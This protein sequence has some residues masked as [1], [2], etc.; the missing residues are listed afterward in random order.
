MAKKPAPQPVDQSRAVSR[1]E[2]ERGD[3]AH[4]F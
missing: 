2:V 3:V 4:V 1:V